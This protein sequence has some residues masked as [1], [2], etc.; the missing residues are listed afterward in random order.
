MGGPA[1]RVSAAR[2]G[3]MAATPTRAAGPT[4]A[5]GPAQGGPRGP[6]GRQGPRL[7]DMGLRTHTLTGRIRLTVEPGAGGDGGRGGAGG[8]GSMGPST[9]LFGV[10]QGG[11]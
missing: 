6:S 11:R 3:P 5:G 7:Y 8:D 1:N 9:T 10:G 4:R 2:M